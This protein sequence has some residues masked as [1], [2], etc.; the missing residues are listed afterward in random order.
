MAVRK[1]Q[2]EKEVIFFITFTCYKWLPLFELTEAYDAIYK[3]F[4]YMKKFDNQVTGFVIMPN[5]LHLMLFVS[6]KSPDLNTLIGNGKR[7]LAY[8]IVKRLKGQEAWL[9]LGQLQGALTSH[10]VKQ[11]KKHKVF[12]PSFDAK[13]CNSRKFIIQKINYIHRNPISGKW[14]LADD[15][16]QYPHSSAGQYELGTPA[17]FEVV[18]FRDLGQ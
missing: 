4:R 6:K 15:W 9:L 5:H 7:F 18:D 2:S 17:I 3:W 13:I 14:N 12:E 1:Y 11:G 10:E 16:V 8:E